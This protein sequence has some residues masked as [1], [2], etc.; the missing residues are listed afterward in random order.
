M[1]RGE[2]NKCGLQA[3][4]EAKPASSSAA[5]RLTWFHLSRSLCPGELHVV[6]GYEAGDIEGRSKRVGTGSLESQR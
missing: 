2:K 1:L 4:V 3:L 6:F 5:P